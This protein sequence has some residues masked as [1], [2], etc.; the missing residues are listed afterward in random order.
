MRARSALPLFSA[1]ALALSTLLPL[2]ASAQ[3][4]VDESPPPS[5]QEV[6]ELATSH[7]PSAALVAAAQV[8]AAGETACDATVLAEAEGS[9]AE[10]AVLLRRAQGLDTEAGRVATD[11]EAAAELRSAADT[12]YAQAL[13]LDLGLTAAFD[14]LT[15]DPGSEAP[16]AEAA[17]A[18]ARLVDLG[19]RAEA[20]ELLLT[21]VEEG[22]VDPK[23]LDQALQDLLAPSPPET[24]VDWWD[25]DGRTWLTVVAWCLAGLALIYLV[26]W[27][28]V[29]RP[30]YRIDPATQAVTAGKADDVAQAWAEMLPRR[31]DDLAES[32]PAMRISTGPDTDL[33][34]PDIDGMPSGFKAVVEFWT[35]FRRL[36]VRHVSA[37]LHD[38][39][40][41]VGVT[42]S[43]R[44][45]SGRLL[46]TR[47][48]RPLDDTAPVERATYLGLLPQAAVWIAFQ[49]TVKRHRVAV[50][51]TRSEVAVLRFADSAAL[52]AAGD[53]GAARQ[54]LLRAR[55]ADPQMLA[56][57]LNLAVL[58]LRREGDDPAA[59]PQDWQ[60]RLEALH[61]VE[62]AA[63]ARLD[64]LFGYAPHVLPAARDRWLREAVRCRATIMRA[65]YNR[66]ISSLNWSA[67]GGTGEMRHDLAAALE[68][69]RKAAVD[70]RESTPRRAR[71][72][73]IRRT[74]HNVERH[75]ELMRRG[76]LDPGPAGFLSDASHQLTTI[77]PDWGAAYPDVLPGW[78]D[79][80][81]A[82]V[83]AAV[84]P[85][86]PGA[87][88]RQAAVARVQSWLDRA[89]AKQPGH[90]VSAARR[91]PFFAH[92]V[93][94][95]P[96]RATAGPRPAPSGPTTE[97]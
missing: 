48:L 34:L 23:K 79:Y 45:R 61:G 75:A 25:E 29:R 66:A 90:Y 72:D 31:L 4:A 35:W 17:V 84:V 43:I 52:L 96:E 36:R 87:P 81:I 88:T 39:G 2:G 49:T 38:E 69:T 6:I 3:T 65:C 27:T 86:D 50:L 80:G 67:A 55:A 1:L 21:A 7:R 54:A 62:Q 57:R 5:C 73:A 89:F 76:H 85:P 37:L 26:L 19:H 20:R 94:V 64:E 30:P 12:S 15:S 60:V 93:P 92:L 74:A 28:W 56:A 32:T 58:D 22:K 18:A 24:V 97:A 91:D 8:E 11:T 14:G 68:S 40:G 10:A 13:A 16:P 83:A 95:P 82:C 41:K 47:T 46:E 71:W 63:S 51:G 77:E 33:T 9:V 59:A 78:V 53:K 70:L 44:K 42:V